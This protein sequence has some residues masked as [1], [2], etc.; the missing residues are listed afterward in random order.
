MKKN[1]LTLLLAITSLMAVATETPKYL[2]IWAKNGSMA[3]YAL[4]DSP[5]I[6][7]AESTVA[8]NKDGQ[9]TP[10]SV[11]EMQCFTYESVMPG[12]V[13]GDDKVDI[14]D[15]TKTISHLIS[16]T[17]SDFPEHTADRDGVVNSEDVTVMLNI[18]VNGQNT[19]KPVSD[20]QPTDET[21]Y[22]YRNDGQFNA[23][24]R[25][26]VEKMEYSN[27]DADSIYHN[28]TITQLV[29]T[30]D[31]I[32]KIPLSSIDSVSFVTP[33][34]KY[35]P[36]VVKMEPLLPYIIG[37]DG[38]TL[39]FSTDTPLD[40]LPKTDDILVLD[41][42]DYEQFPTGFAGRMASKSG[43]Q[44]ICDSVSF[45]DIYEQII[46]YGR[47]TAIDDSPFENGRMRFAARKKV[48]GNLSTS[49]Q[50]KGTLGTSGTG[51]YATLDG[52]AG[53]DLRF[54]FKYNTGEPV[55]FDI[56]LAPEFSLSFEAG[57]QGS[58]NPEPLESK[59]PLLLIPIPD[60]PFYFKVNGGPILEVAVKASVVAKTD[61]KLG[62][63]FGVKYENGIFKGYGSNTSKWFS[64]PDITGS[65]DGSVFLGL[66]LESGIYSYGDMVKL[67]I[68]KKAG[69]EIEASISENIKNPISYED[70][71]DDYLD[72][73][74]KASAAFKAE[75]KI[76]KW[77]KLSAKHDILSGKFNVLRYKIVPTFTKP[78]VSIDKMS[79]A[80]SVIP[81]NNLLFPVSVGIGLW[82]DNNN[83]PDS[84]FCEETYLNKDSWSLSEYNTIFTDLSPITEYTVR[85]IV[86]L[87]GGTIVASPEE[88]F[89]IPT[90]PLTLDALNVKSSSAKVYG[91]IEGLEMIDGNANYGIGYT[92][93]G[94][95]GKTLFDAM[96]N[97][98]SGLFSVNLTGL[99]PNTTYK[100]FAYLIIE[101]ETIYGKT[102]QF[103]TKQNYCPDDNHPHM[104]DLG[105]PSGTL[106]ACCNV[107]ASTPEEFGGYYAWGETH[108]KNVYTW[109]SY[110]YYNE[111]DGLVYIGSDIAGTY[112][113][114]ATSNWGAPWRM[115]TKDQFAELWANT[116]TS[117]EGKYL[118]GVGGRT[119]IGCN[120]N[121]I[122]LP[123]A[124][125]YN[126]GTMNGGRYWSSTLGYTSSHAYSPRFND[127]ESVPQGSSER[128]YGL[129]VRPVR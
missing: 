119:F 28:E 67:V 121:R 25:D 43:Q 62:Y 9:E 56:S 46:C 30:T 69:P 106:W 94:E 74:L 14:V 110:Q 103:T 11:E 73:N 66:K 81:E 20:Q 86:K 17:R 70:L 2:V 19:V 128:Y 116:S 12:D 34:T 31:S 13:N 42:F 4:K 77:V 76:F 127:V 55:Y 32:Y 79:A 126:E 72:V 100:Y 95:T 129:S 91:K 109:A 41:N 26:E 59:V 68:E 10:F 111:N 88:T 6:T 40:I 118:N 36:K 96:D 71:C 123:Y 1:L 44:I 3:T 113:D 65:I 104:I 39:T 122:F 63:K 64:K 97:Y 15:V 80:V 78:S 18:I 120:G 92:T 23:F 37:V 53:L 101:G 90:Y 8:V 107:G 58:Y 93:E 27:Y 125:G 49:V 114:A 84:H 52:R 108:T 61:A 33:E 112:Y 38:M 83:I 35:T 105:L 57:I 98:G 47:Y 102:D 22:I 54:T 124:G 5:R 60:T 48:E 24:F 75:A 117:Y 29:Y 82:D 99:K 21:F 7:F 50:V 87:F 85:P 16:F 115:P 51:L 89:K 45:E